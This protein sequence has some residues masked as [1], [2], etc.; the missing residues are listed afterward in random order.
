MGTAASAPPNTPTDSEA[1][2]VSAYVDSRLRATE[3]L[4][5]HPDRQTMQ[6]SILELRRIDQALWDL[7]SEDGGNYPLREILNRTID[8]KARLARLPPALLLSL[9]QLR[10]H[11]APL[12]HRPAFGYRIV[13]FDAL[14]E[15]LEENAR[16]G[17]FRLSAPPPAIF[18]YL[19]S[20]LEELVG[21]SPIKAGIQ[22]V[23]LLFMLRD[24]FLLYLGAR[25]LQSTGHAVEARAALLNRAMLQSFVA[26]SPRNPLY[27][28][29]YNM[30]F[31]CRQNTDE[32]FSHIFV[33]HCSR[34]WRLAQIPGK[35]GFD[36]FLRGYLDERL[37]SDGEYLAVDTGAYGTMPLLAMITDGRVQGLRLYTAS[38][39]LQDF[40]ERELHCRD[41]E[42]VRELETL[43]CQETLFSF[44]ASEGRAILVKVSQ[45]PEIWA[46]STAEIGAFLSHVDKRFGTSKLTF[47]IQGVTPD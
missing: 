21:P 22:P 29:L 16:R 26:E 47:N 33:E 23:R 2:F 30:I 42:R 24:T 34:A 6:E 9:S 15:E 40:Y 44:A 37:G 5:P 17:E 31:E 46:R 8:L 12:P 19:I 41:S 36:A 11:A 25:R 20:Y 28:H 14:L 7:N 39:W 27:A 38:P 43:T 4:G 32:R 13:E 3:A 45:D 1:R 35:D 18:D 10:A